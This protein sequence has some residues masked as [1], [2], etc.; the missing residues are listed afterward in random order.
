MRLQIREKKEGK[1]RGRGGKRQGDEVGQS[2]REIQKKGCRPEGRNKIGNV[3]EKKEDKNPV[4]TK[5]RFK[6]RGHLGRPKREKEREKRRAASG[7]RQRA[8][9]VNTRKKKWES[10]ARRESGGKD[11]RRKTLGK[12]KGHGGEKATFFSAGTYTGKGGRRLVLPAEDI[13]RKCF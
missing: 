9:A 8:P 11:L 4:T 5:K 12:G 10:P 6:R 3:P 13:L 7:G 2:R 1:T